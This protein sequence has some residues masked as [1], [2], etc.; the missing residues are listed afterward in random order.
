[1]AANELSTWKIVLKLALVGFGVLCFWGTSIAWV[2][3]QIR[4]LVGVIFYGGASE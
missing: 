3:F 2:V 1:M 4:R